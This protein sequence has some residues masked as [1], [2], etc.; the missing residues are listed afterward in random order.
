MRGLGTKVKQTAFLKF[1]VDAI[2]SS[3]VCIQKIH[4]YR[5]PGTSLGEI[6]ASRKND[7]QRTHM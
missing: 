6:A 3:E 7:T 1:F 4:A 2:F 5:F